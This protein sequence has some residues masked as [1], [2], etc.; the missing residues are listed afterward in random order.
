MASSGLLVER[1][2]LPTPLLYLS[3]FVE[4][5]RQDDYR[6]LRAVSERAAW[7]SWLHYALNGMARQSEYA[8][9]RAERLSETLAAWRMQVAGTASEVQAALVDRLAANPYVTCEKD[10]TGAGRCLHGGTAVWRNCES[11]RSS[12]RPAKGSVTARIARQ[13]Y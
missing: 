9:R 5:T 6:A 1:A 11:Y 3:A 8:L 7:E 13:L 4:A 2:I 10:R 12:R